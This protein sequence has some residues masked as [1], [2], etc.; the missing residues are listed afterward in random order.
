[1]SETAVN[2]VGAHVDDKGRTLV[3]HML[4]RELLEEIAV[5]QRA[6]ADMVTEFVTAMQGNKMLSM[7]AGKLGK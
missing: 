7:F 3:E 2:P 4:D 1:M 6:T 5:N